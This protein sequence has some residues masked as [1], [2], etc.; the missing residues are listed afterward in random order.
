MPVRNSDFIKPLHKDMH[1]VGL[2]LGVD[3]PMIKKIVLRCRHSFPVVVILDPFFQDA[4]N[5]TAL[6]NLIWLT[7]PHLNKKIHHLESKSLIPQIGETIMQDSSYTHSMKKAHAQFALLRL[8]MCGDK[9]KDFNSFSKIFDT[10]IGGIRDTEQVKCLHL[11]YAHSLICKHNIAGNIVSK[12]LGDD[13][14]CSE[15]NCRNLKVS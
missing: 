11:H 10:G 9:F 3:K 4:L 5:F 12:L 15:M 1:D 6:V 8:K 7:C 2:Q 13:V 14:S